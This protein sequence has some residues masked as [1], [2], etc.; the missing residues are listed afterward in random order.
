MARIELPLTDLVRAVTEP[1]RQQVRRAV[2]DAGFR[3]VT[4]D[5]AGMQSGVF[6]LTVLQD[7]RTE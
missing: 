7:M 3:Y 2:V 6:T 4:V 5:L 1:I